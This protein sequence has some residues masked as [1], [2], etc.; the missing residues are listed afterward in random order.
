MLESTVVDRLGS[1]V[2][3]RLGG[4][5]ARSY[6]ALGALLLIAAFAVSAV[7]R[8]DALRDARSS[9]W[10]ASAVERVLAAERILDR[11][12]AGALLAVRALSSATFENAPARLDL[13]HE[14]L[15]RLQRH[16]GA[17]GAESA[18]KPLTWLALGALAD[19]ARAQDMRT[20]E[21]AREWLREEARA[22][23]GVKPASDASSGAIRRALGFLH[24]ARVASGADPTGDAT[25]LALYSL[26]GGPFDLRVAYADAIATDGARRT[27]SAASP[28]CEG[29]DG[30]LYA[31]AL[32]VAVLDHYRRSQE[33][34]LLAESTRP[35]ASIERELEARRDATSGAWSREPGSAA[36]VVATACALLIQDTLE[37]WS[38]TQR[39]RARTD[40]LDA[41]R[42]YAHSVQTC[43]PC[44]ATL[45]PAQFAQWND[46]THARKK[47]GCA[48]C[49]G[50]NHSLIF[51]ENGRVSP[52]A[53]ARCHAEAVAQFANSKHAH[54][55]D[56]LLASALY[57]AT[58]TA[59]RASCRTCHRIGEK[60]SDG[61][62]GNC[63]QCHA[64]HMFDASSAREP[65]ACTVCHTGADYPQDE[66]YRLSKH[67]ALYATTRDVVVAPTCTTC[68]QP[69]GRHDDGFGITIGG[70]G[71]GAVLDGAP[72][73]FAQEHLSTTDFAEGRAAM[74]A[75]CTNCHSS[76]LAEASLR[77]AD[78]LKREGEAHLVEAAAIVRALGDEGLLDAANV[79]ALGPAYAPPNPDARGAAL[80]ER[81]YRMWRFDHAT[82][83]KGSYHQSASLA[84]HSSGAGTR[85][86]LDFI[87][88]EA[89]R[90]R[91]PRGREHGAKR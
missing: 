65:E 16:D 38:A 57:A 23:S 30:A 39:E 81:F 32:D 77:E 90:L 19:S 70:S 5:R 60:H 86:A 45:Q 25:T 9:E 22:R 51:R 68:H 59:L 4:A 50:E 53:C 43:E 17:F 76:R 14:R 36:E 85:E 79:Q 78:E 73:A 75:I 28:T 12:L 54:A 18:S 88:A 1:Q 15:G 42:D 52:T 44:H 37:R 41:P 26:A 10:L 84:N 7:R 91:D 69:G 24:T 72:A 74:V 8:R 29:L 55:E 87:R 46:S 27:P 13:L 89:A 48:D 40:A 64:G 49:H 58:P 20:F 66:A 2:A 3:S 21:R 56:M 47:V 34:A 61:S 33:A 80:L 83:W 71:I 31:L 35:T 67:G 82:A 62:T 11:D 63:N 6:V